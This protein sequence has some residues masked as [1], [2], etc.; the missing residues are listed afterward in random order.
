MNK[1]FKPK[2]P[3][4][5]PSIYW[6][7]WVVIIHYVTTKASK[8]YQFIIFTS[9][10][11]RLFLF[12]CVTQ[13]PVYIGRNNIVMLIKNLRPDLTVRKQVSHQ[14]F[15]IQPKSDSNIAW[16]YTRHKARTIHQLIKILIRQ[17]TPYFTPLHNYKQTRVPWTQILGR[18]CLT[19][20]W[21]EIFWFHCWC[22]SMKWYR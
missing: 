20:R 9:K 19:K 12:K 18:D 6:R 14:K 16:R 8:K 5:T 17:T 11:I 10:S 15:Y 2:R 7:A 22:L 1:K 13:K 21:C 4:S 3:L